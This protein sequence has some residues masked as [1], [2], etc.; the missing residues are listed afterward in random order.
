MAQHSIDLLPAS[1]RA[2]TEAGVRTGRLI[3]GA[4]AMLVLMLVLSVHSLMTLANS[5]EELFTTAIR[6]EQVF[7]TEA[8]IL[9]LKA[10]L[11]R[12][13]DHIELYDKIASP[14]PMSAVMATVINNLPE[15]VTLDQ[16]DIDA[17]ARAITRAPRAKGVE[18]KDE[19]P[20]RVLHGEVSGFAASDQHIAELVGRLTAHPL[21]RDVNLDFSRTRDVNK[22]DAR[23]FR[24]SFKIDLDTAYRISF[25]QPASTSER[26]V[27]AEH[28]STGREHQ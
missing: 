13:S 21:F 16:F 7:E 17:G 15:S 8:K 3:V 22:R 26:I 28:D 1:I 12:T 9:E 4:T 25:R 23:E 2:R 5:Q 27:G 18:T 24:L 20:P 6:A 14:V 19:I 10:K 11:K